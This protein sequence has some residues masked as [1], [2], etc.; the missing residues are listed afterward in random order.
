MAKTD[1]A[2]MAQCSAASQ[3]TT[4]GAIHKTRVQSRNCKQEKVF[5]AFMHMP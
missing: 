5:K 2:T 3:H 1:S 4:S